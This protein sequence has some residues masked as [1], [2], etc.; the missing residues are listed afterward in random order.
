MPEFRE[1]ETHLSIRPPDVIAHRGFSAENP[2]NTLISYQNAVKA[3]TTALEGDIRL[4]KDNEIIMMHDTTLDRV[5]TGTG[6]VND[7]NWYGYIEH[8]KSRKEPAQPITRFKDVLDYL[9]KP[10]ISLMDGLYMI[11]DIKFDNPIKILSVLHDLLDPYIENYPKLYH[12]LI[13][14]IWNVDFLK[15]AKELFPKFRLCFIGLSIAAARS[16]FIDHVDFVSLPFAALANQDGQTFIKEVH[17]RRKSIFTWTIN[18]PLQMRTCV[19]WGVD[20]VIGDN[21][22]TLLEFVQNQPKSLTSVQEYEEYKKSDVFLLS[23]RTRLYYYIVARIM[24]LLSW[25]RIGI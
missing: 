15:R 19:L 17:E 2:E 1:K 4:S 6:L 10:D 9:V 22:N 20:G 25:R 11:I 8:L 24:R 14:G 3:G 12:Q 21:V 23:I 16:H 7:C 5:T 13:I 18:D